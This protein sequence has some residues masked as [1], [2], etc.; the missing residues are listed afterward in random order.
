MSLNLKLLHRKKTKMGALKVSVL[1]VFINLLF[2]S[3]LFAQGTRNISG[4]VSSNGETLIGASVIEVGSSNGAITD[5]D[6][7]FTLSVKENATLRISYLGYK[8]K[9]IKVG[10]QNVLNVEMIEDV[11]VLDEVVAIGYGVQKKKLITGATVQ[12]KGDDIT[13]MSTVSALSALQS[14]TPG[15]NITKMSGKPGEGFR[16][17]IRGIGSVSADVAPLYIIDG[18]PAGNESSAI[19]DLNP[20]DIESVDVLKDGASTAIYGARG[21]N[22]V[23]LITTKQGKK[24][25]ASIQYDGYVGWQNVYK[26]LTPLNAEQYMTI[27]DEASGIKNN[28]F[29]AGGMSQYDQDAYNS[30]AWT[31]TNWLDEMIL[32]NAPI[33]NHTINITGGTDM[34]KYSLGFGYTSQSPI[35]GVENG[36][37]DPKYERYNFRINSD[38]DLIKIR[39]YTLLQVGQTLT[40]VYKNNDAMSMATSHKDWNDVRN[41]LTAN[42]LYQLYDT[43]GNYNK[44]GWNAS[45]ENN[46]IAQMYYNSFTNSQNYS[47]RGNTYMVLQPIKNLKNR[48][49]FGFTYSGWQSRQYRPV[50]DMGKDN[51]KN[52]KTSQGSGNGIGWVFDNVLTYDFVV[53]DVHSVTAMLGFSAEKSGL[54]QNVDA[55]S[56]NSQFTDFEHAYVNNGKY[57]DASLISMGGSPW[58]RNTM[59]SVFGRLNYDYKGT[60]MATA[61]IRHDGSSRFARGQRWGT[62]PSVS[63]G[64][65]VTNESFME[66]SSSWLDFLK[67]RASYGQN[68][69]N[70]VPYFRFAGNVNVTGGKYF[71]GDNK[72]STTDGAFQENIG[73]PD[74]KW[75]TSEQINL[76]FDTW[77]LK[78]RLGLN[79]DYYVKNTKDWL[80]QPPGLGSWG[81]GVPWLNGG[82]VRNS[83]LE[84]MLTWQDKINDFSYSVT[85]NFAYNKNKVTKIANSEKIIHGASSILSQQS[86][87]MYRAQEGLPIGYFYGYKANGIIQTQA[88]ADEY[89]QKYKIYDGEKL[90]ISQPG[91][92]KYVD[93]FEDGVIDDKDKTMIGNPHPDFTYGVTVNLA[94][95]GLDLS[96]TGTGVGG[97]QIAQSY[98]SYMDSPNQNYTT[99]IL[100]R[101]TGEG[102]SNKLPRLG[103]G[104]IVRNWSKVSDQLF[105]EDGDYFRISNLTLGYDLNQ[106]FKKKSP[107]AQVRIFG[108]VQNLV[109]F[110]NYSGMDPEIGYGNSDS[111]VKGID[112]GTYP[113]ARTFLMGITIKY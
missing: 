26:K 107:L 13:K 16:V 78:N 58:D 80:V 22:G 48:T 32:K 4:T 93:T 49:S 88:E 100:G 89:N 50:F 3:S 62:F 43:D 30:G 59:A 2:V 12:I 40:L 105:I 108:T 112:L 14:Q 75:E 81:T 79:F 21:G 19:N 44:P 55:Q 111:W 27:V 10:A 56:Y 113:S 77:F 31:G 82:D 46:P 6:G 84:I 42:P 1:F 29:G 101:W 60:Y 63:A 28:Y 11:N 72:S 38:H 74:L 85:S 47:A 39:D 71:F 17:L 109:T 52:D 91:D 66:D 65:V 18:I 61:V 69:N 110:T 99:D 7:K 73:N 92:V 96:V 35:I 104:S 20:A 76:G 106:L 54:G 25:K 64:W 33:T 9:E 103:P 57:N 45:A 23:I 53:E 8:D 67:L 41:A 102:T 94:W 70:T 24:G 87:E 37:I 51:Y 83:G 86:G 15:V 34:S 36:E 97:N 98:R 95:K 90:I 5:I 68:G